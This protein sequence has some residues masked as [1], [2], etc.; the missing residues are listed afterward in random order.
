MSRK[1][2][3]FSVLLLAVFAFA[4]T[5]RAQF[6]SNLQG[7]VTDS[8]GA[9]I[10]GATVLLTNTATNVSRQTTSTASGDYRFVSVAPGAYEVTT[11][12]KGFATHKV[13]IQLQTEQTMNLP[14]TLS[15]SSQT[16]TVEVTDQAPVLDTAETRNQLTI[17]TEELDSLPLPGHDQLGLVTLAPGVTGLGVIGSG[18]NGQSNDNYAAETQVTASANGRSSVGN[19][20]VVDGLDITSNITPGVLNLVP[21]PDTV[22]EATVQVNTFNVEYGRSSSVVEVMTTRAGSEKY[23]FLASDYYTANFLTARTEFQPRESF[24]M[25]P[26]HSDNLS[27]TLSGPI[28]LLKQ[29]YF[30]TGWEPLLSSTQSSSQITVEDPAFTTWAQQNWPNSI[31][32]KLLA[33]YPSV[34]VSRTGVQSTGSSLLGATTCGTP[35]GANIPCTLPIVDNGVFNAT[36]YRN[37]LEFNVRL[38]KYFNKDRVYANYYRTSL[39]TGGPSVRVGHGA[40]QQYLVRSIQANET[41][42]FNDH[43]LNEAAFGFLRMEGLIDPY[44]PFHIP[45]ISVSTA[46][47]TGLGVSKAHENYIQHHFQWKDDVGY[48]RGPHD[49]KVG[50][51][52]FHGDNLTYFG[53]WDSQPNFSFLTVPA[54]LQDQ[55]Y[56]ETGVSYNLLTGQPAGLASG[57]FQFTGNTNGI[58]AQDNWKIGK[59]LTLTYGLRWDN[60]GNPTPENGTVEANFFYG[61]GSNVQQQIASGSVKQVSAAFNQSIKA[62]SPRAGVAYDLTGSGKWLVHGGFGLYHDWVTL[63]NVQNEFANPP[64]PAGVTFQSNTSGTAPIYSVGTSDTWPFGFTYPSLPAASL[65]S[66]GGITGQQINIAGND[67]NLKASN[68]MNYTVTLERGLGNSYSVAVGYSGSHSNNLF[69]DFAGHTTNAYYGVD[70]NN[71]PGSLIQNNGKLVRLNTSFGTIRYT[72]NGPTSTYNAFIAEFK[73]RF[74]KHGF[75]DSSYTRSS[76]YDD[77]GTYPTVQ[78]NTGNYSQYWAPSIWDVP[79]RVSM[80]V[81][82]ELPHLNRGP[83][84]LHYVTDG[85][86]PTAIT[87][88]QSGQPFTV[89]NTAAY[90][91]STV[92]GAAVTTKLGDYN[93]DG[94]NSDLPN[95]PTYGYNIPT[96]RNH[97]LARG[98]NLVPI[99]AGA[100]GSTGVFTALGDFTNPGTLPGEGNEV[101]NG[102]RS[103]GY[104]NTDFALL[105]NNRIR[106]FAN[107]QLRLEMFNL[108]NR[109]SL[110]SLNGSTTSSSFGKATSQY[111]ARFLQLGA[112]FEF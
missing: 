92:A 51:E 14:V 70:V 39:H 12:A 7:V 43:L 108:F 112:R 88:L 50:Y 47:G 4:A 30:F 41:H 15:I 8:T 46:W 5:G 73:G 13:Q 53:Q 25:L 94:T 45:I 19:M 82:Y 23:H 69:T 77:A 57:S 65:N 109:A 103:P 34:N 11:S 67:P 6:S 79:N 26:F 49:I 64:A 68:T 37:A 76:S 78:S 3:R 62:W 60:F 111:N 29:T 90:S 105:K 2:M 44:G 86:K 35:A 95:V 10:Q 106:E 104:A 61:Q 84:F 1:A 27:A 22:Q 56:Q 93:A 85:W 101:I 58:F 71:F 55:V 74:L 48:V 63:G 52:G 17:T 66:Q 75:I 32:V 107:L 18:G 81:A 38:D 102:Y 54:F 31:G 21:N 97:Q 100:S 36:N 28:P 59:R 96:D 16:Q 72:V 83:G 40:P 9:L 80:Q 20:F 87:I 24:T 98:A 110:G 99:A 33:Q 42:T 91:A 89:L